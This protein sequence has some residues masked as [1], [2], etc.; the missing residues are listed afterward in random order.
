MWFGPG[1]PSAN[2]YERIGLYFHFNDKSG[3]IIPRSSVRHSPPLPTREFPAKP[4]SV[5]SMPQ[6]TRP[7]CRVCLRCCL[8]KGLPHRG[9]RGFRWPKF[10]GCYVTKFA[11]HKAP[12]LIARGKLTFDARVV[13]HRASGVRPCPEYSRANSYPWN[14]FLQRRARPGPCPHSAGGIHQ[15]VAQEVF[16]VG[17]VAG[18]DVR[19]GTARPRS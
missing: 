3:V 7:R 16:E 2:Y 4:L 13:L 10:L 14:R 11:P 12:K 1:Q 19:I 15:T 5:Y 17:C 9:V 6:T 18:A 8:L